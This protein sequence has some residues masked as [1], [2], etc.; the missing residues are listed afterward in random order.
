MFKLWLPG[1]ASWIGPKYFWVGGGWQLEYSV[2]FY[3][4]KPVM[5]LFSLHNYVL[6]IGKHIE[7][8]YA[9]SMGCCNQQLEIKLVIQKHILNP[10][11]EKNKA[12]NKIL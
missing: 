4:C 3:I 8:Q 9:T 12:A 2:A 11:A 6:V 10:F 5:Q 1:Y 7:L